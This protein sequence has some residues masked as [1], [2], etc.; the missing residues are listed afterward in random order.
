LFNAEAVLLIDDQ[1]SKI[2]ELDIWVEESVGPDDDID[3]AMGKRFEGALI[4][5]R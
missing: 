5:R 4:V 1:E 3:L 2:F